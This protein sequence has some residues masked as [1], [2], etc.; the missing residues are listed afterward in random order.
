MKIRTDFVTNSS[1]SS[2]IVLSLRDN[3]IEKILELEGIKDDDDQYNTI[4]DNGFKMSN[5]DAI[6]SDY[7]LEYLGR[8]LTED[9]LRKKTLN[10]LEIELVDEINR[11]YNLGITIDDVFFDFGEVYN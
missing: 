10:Q 4:T 7:E 9:D 5:I 11:A 2:F 6:F 8:E 3:V 1:S